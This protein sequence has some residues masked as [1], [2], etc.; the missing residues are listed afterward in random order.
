[1]R[2]DVIGL[3]TVSGSAQFSTHERARGRVLA[4][5]H[6][7]AAGWRATAGAPSSVRLLAELASS[8]KRQEGKRALGLGFVR[9]EGFIR[10]IFAL[11]R[12]IEW[13]PHQSMMARRVGTELDNLVAQ[14]E[15][16]GLLAPVEERVGYEQLG[17]FVG[18]HVGFRA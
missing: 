2:A 7:P 13:T 14:A 5:L 15:V 18:P 10:P 16:I 8:E 4:G 17:R 6:T 3:R 9:V 1:M 11:S 12:L